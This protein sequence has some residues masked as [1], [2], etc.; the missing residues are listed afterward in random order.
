[1]S[2]CLSL[3]SKG[4]L[5]CLYFGSTGKAPPNLP[6]GVPPLLHNQYIVGPGG[7]LPA[8][9]VSNLIVPV[10]VYLNLGASGPSR[11]AAVYAKALVLS[12]IALGILLPNAEEM[13]SI[14]WELNVHRKF[15]NWCSCCQS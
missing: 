7:L 10:L 9:P 4:L 11:P 3:F 12:C 13:Q 5:K 14:Q 8:Y 15:Q 2:R 6:Q 1:M